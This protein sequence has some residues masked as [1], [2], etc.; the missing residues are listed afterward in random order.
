VDYDPENPETYE[1]EEDEDYKHEDSDE[2]SWV[3]PDEDRMSP[4]REE[5]WWA[6]L[7]ARP[8][9]ANTDS[10][11]EWDSDFDLIDQDK[12]N[13]LLNKEDPNPVVT[14]TPRTYTHTEEWRSCPTHFQKQKLQEWSKADPGVA[15]NQSHTSCPLMHS[16]PSPSWTR[17]C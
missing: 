3:N 12:I 14:R 5:Q 2:D 11:S 1:D 4:E 13:D 15:Q 9:N 7:E 6:D 10:E 16:W 17:T 8:N